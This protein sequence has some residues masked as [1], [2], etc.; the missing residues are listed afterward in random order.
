MKNKVTKLKEL[1]MLYLKIDVLFLTDIFQNYV[2]T[3][4]KTYGI[5]PFYSYST[6]SFTWKAGLKMT[7]VNL[8]YII[9]DQLRILLENNMRGGPSSCMS[10]RY[11]EREE[12]RIV[13]EDMNNLY[14]WN[15]SQYLPSGDF[16]EIEVT[17][18]GVKTFLRTPDNH[19]NGFFKRM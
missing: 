11:V 1:T 8:I 12:R 5:N 2:D 10:S 6:P 13:N 3:C 9:D 15:M 14:G 4:K 19:E 16:R 7:G 18:S 17:R